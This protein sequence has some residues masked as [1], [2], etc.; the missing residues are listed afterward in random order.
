MLRSVEL[1]GIIAITVFAHQ[2]PYIVLL[3]ITFGTPLLQNFLNEPNVVIHPMLTTAQK[4]FMWVIRLMV[5][6]C[7]MHMYMYEM[8]QDC[9]YCILHF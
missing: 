4:N 6:A 3:Q 7:N 8:I 2:S 5:D 9:H 1:I